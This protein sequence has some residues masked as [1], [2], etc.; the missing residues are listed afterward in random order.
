M[1]ITIMFTNSVKYQAKKTIAG[2]IAQQRTS[3]V[4]CTCISAV[5]TV[6]K[7]NVFGQK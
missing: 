4:T 5:S 7:Y 6:L 1:H 3:A 2:K